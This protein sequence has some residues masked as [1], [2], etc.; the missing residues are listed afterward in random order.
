M[1]SAFSRSRGTHGATG[2]MRLMRSMRL[3]GTASRRTYP[4]EVPC[5]RPPNSCIRCRYSQA[6]PELLRRNSFDFWPFDGL[7]TNSE[8]AQNVISN[9]PA[10]GLSG[11][12]N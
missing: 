2:F 12:C 9:S 8:S 3:N 11:S 5:S 7:V 4:V 6:S 1:G 10:S